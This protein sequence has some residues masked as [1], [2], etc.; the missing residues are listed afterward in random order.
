MSKR[1][2]KDQ[3]SFVLPHVVVCDDT[4]Q[5]LEVVHHLTTN[6]ARVEA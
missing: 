5:L 4:A 2:T 6:G 1:W 3:G